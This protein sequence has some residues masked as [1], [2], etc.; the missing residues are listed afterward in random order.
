MTDQWGGVVAVSG[1][2]TNS[3]NPRQGQAFD[4][5]SSGYY[6]NQQQQQQQYGG[7][8]QYALSASVRRGN[9]YESTVTSPR[10]GNTTSGLNNTFSNSTIVNEHGVGPSRTDVLALATTDPARMGV[11]MGRTTEANSSYFGLI[12]GEGVDST[13]WRPGLKGSSSQEAG[14]LEEI[15]MRGED[16]NQDILVS[17]R[18]TEELE[19]NFSTPDGRLFNINNDRYKYSRSKLAMRGLNGMPEDGMVAVGAVK[20]GLRDALPRMTENEY[21][22]MVYRDYSDWAARMYWKEAKKDSAMGRKY[23]ERCFA[24]CVGV[25]AGVFIPITRRQMLRGVDTLVRQAATAHDNDGT[26]NSPN[27]GGANGGA[28]E[29]FALTSAQFSALGV[30]RGPAN[31]EGA[32]G[33]GGRGGHRSN[34]GGD[35]SYPSNYPSPWDWSPAAIQRRI[36]FYLEQKYKAVGQF[37]VKG[38]IVVGVGYVVV[39]YLKSGRGNNNNNNGYNNGGYNNNG[40]APRSSRLARHQARMQQQQ[41]NS[42]NGNGN[43][44]EGPGLFGALLNPKAMFDYALAP[45]R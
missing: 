42:N 10:L 39:G 26:G 21:H 16:Y 1:G 38:L 40:D 12:V 45:S 11:S 29:C 18:P 30:L 31:D 9:G 43:G 6:G 32:D 8:Q 14:L 41:S 15:Y 24:L 13:F 2:Q 36:G 27:A 5:N 34:R 4:G 25:D 23:V 20:S 19:C 35:S 44:N 33:G 28:L 37:I 3:Y 7:G 22:L 17:S